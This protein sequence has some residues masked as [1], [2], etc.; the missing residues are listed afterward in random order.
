LEGLAQGDRRKEGCEVTVSLEIIRLRP[1]HADMLAELF[2]GI[3][4]DP[5][6]SRFHPH[7]FT[8]EE[9]HRI[10][11][12]S[13]QDV[14]QAL[15]VDGCRLL[16]YGMLRGWDEGFTVPSLGIYVASELR[17]S[18]AARLMMEHLHLTAHLSGAQQIRLKVYPENQAAYRLY[19]S[20][21]YQFSEQA[22]PE[23]QLIGILELDV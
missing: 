14:Y 11:K 1:E 19:A 2:A 16:A 7:P 17:G 6:S 18:G 21:G 15:L 12:H 20:L 5:L 22:S 23:G 13:G 10:C 3:A 4:V 9:A 8:K